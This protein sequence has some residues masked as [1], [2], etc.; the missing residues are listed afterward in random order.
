MS[1]CF[2]P[3][4]LPTDAETPRKAMAPAAQMGKE[5]HQQV[6]QQSS[7]Y[8]PLDCVLVA[9]DEI[10][11]LHRLLQLLEEHFDFP[12]CPIQFG[13]GPRTPINIVGDKGHGDILAVDLNDRLHQPCRSK[14]PAVPGNVRTTQVDDRG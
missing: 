13:Y 10:N 8:L 12:P 14:G 11:Q 5:P 6:S 7:P 1:K 2:E 3:M 9:A 4:H